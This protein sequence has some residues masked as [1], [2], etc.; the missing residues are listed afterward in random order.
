MKE[1]LGLSY[2]DM[3]GLHKI[4]DGIPDRARWQH[5]T[6]SFGDHPDDEYLLQ[7]RD[8]IEAVMALLGN[9]AY[10]KHLV[11]KPSKL[12]KDA[13]RKKRIYNEM[14]TGRWWWTVQVCL[15]IFCIPYGS[16]GCSSAQAR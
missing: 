8:V 1:K 3:N 14:W 11:Y 16:Q 9:P 15:N 4:V 13:S 12:F 7:S 10:A 2:N 5:E 6:L